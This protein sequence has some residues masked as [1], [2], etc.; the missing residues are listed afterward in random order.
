MIEIRRD[1]Y[2]DEDTGERDS[3]LGMIAQDT[4]QAIAA[5]REAVLRSPNW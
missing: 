4:A 1:L 2:M 3:N 5:A